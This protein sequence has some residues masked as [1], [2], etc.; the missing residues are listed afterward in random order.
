M[1]A[2]SVPPGCQGYQPVSELQTV[3]GEQARQSD[4]PGHGQYGQH[5]QKGKNWMDGRALAVARC[6]LGK[7]LG[8]K[9]SSTFYFCLIALTPRPPNR[10][11]T[12]PSF[13]RPVSSPQFP[14]SSE[15]NVL[16]GEQ[17]FLAERLSSIMPSQ[18]FFVS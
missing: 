9:R 3:S 1:R 16:A 2:R 6:N 14:L 18:G 4:W 17:I 12:W 10:I 5:V 15:C 7:A 11:H 13:S 8:G